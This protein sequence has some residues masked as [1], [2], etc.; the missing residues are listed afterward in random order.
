MKQSNGAII[1]KGQSSIDGQ[2]I[3]VIATGITNKSSNIKTGDMVQTWVL[4]DDMKPYEAV[5]TGAD[6]SICGDCKHRGVLIDGKVKGRT[7]YV[8]V[9]QAPT[10]IFNAYKR[11]SYDDMT[12]ADISTIGAD[13]NVRIGAYGDPSAVP[14]SVWQKLTSRSNT[15]TGYTH[16]WKNKANDALKY[17]TMASADN[18]TEYKQAVSM[19]WRTFRVKKADDLKLDNEV[20]CPSTT[21]GLSCAD[22]GACKGLKGDRPMRS[23]IVID[24]HGIGAKAFA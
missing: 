6:Y 23:N 8:T 24:V 13:R 20:V 19:G 10:S 15:T 5:K 11:G 2:N 7:C 12:S 14:V 1:Y 4:L 17:L 3:V 18:E 9:F 22:C 21:V 16:Q